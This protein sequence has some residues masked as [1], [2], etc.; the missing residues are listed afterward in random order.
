MTHQNGGP[1]ATDED[2][3]VMVSDIPSKHVSTPEEDAADVAYVTK[4]LME[5]IARSRAVKSKG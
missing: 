5:A 2:F 3:F 4:N 1:L